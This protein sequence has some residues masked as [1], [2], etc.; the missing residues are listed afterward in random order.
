MTDNLDLLSRFNAEL[1]ALEERG[2]VTLEMHA[3]TAWILLSH[4]QLALRHPANTGP[5]AMLGRDLARSLRDRLAPSGALREVFDRGWNPAFDVEAGNV[6][7]SRRDPGRDGPDVP[8]AASGAVVEGT[9]DQAQ[10]T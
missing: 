8:P 7:D 2:P 9:H 6:T 10:G 3:T 4:L 5:L 1:H